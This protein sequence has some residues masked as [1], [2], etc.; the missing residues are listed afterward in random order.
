LIGSNW[1]A[2]SGYS[3]ATSGNGYAMYLSNGI[4]I[5]DP[6]IPDDGA[7]VCPNE[8]AIF[9]SKPTSWNS[10]INVYIYDNS[11]VPE[12]Y[13][14]LP[15]PGNTMTQVGDGVYK[16]VYTGTPNANWNV[17]FNDGSNQ[18][19]GYGENGFT[20]TQSMIYSIAGANSVVTTACQ[21]CDG[22]TDP[23]PEPLCAPEGTNAIYFQKPAGWGNVNAYAY[24]NSGTEVRPF[25]DWPG[26][27]MTEIDPP[28]NFYKIDLPS[29]PSSNWFVLFNTN[30]SG[31]N[32]AYQVPQEIGFPVSNLGL[33]NSSGFSGIVPICQESSIEYDLTDNITAFASD[34]FFHFQAT[35]NIKQIQI[36]DIT[37]KIITIENCNNKVT[38]ISTNNYKSGV[39]IALIVMENGKTTRK[40]VKR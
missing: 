1:T 27:P 29:A 26:S 3:L 39:Y 15:W 4:I 31:Q 7:C 40:L 12:T 11:T 20:V 38:S 35:S 25:G 24:Y 33:Y 14:T 13:I 30:C 19:P 36:F 21:N 10:T 37:G 17:I 16:Y 6:P 34:K 18:I 8:T 5:I 22:D 28:S 32:C 9:F 2:P 23:D